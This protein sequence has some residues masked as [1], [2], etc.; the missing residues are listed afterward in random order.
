MTG[1]PLLET[2]FHLPTAHGRLVPR[3][4]LSAQITRATS[5]T[6]TLVSAPAGFGKTT[7][8]AELAA[9]PSGARVAWLSLDQ[10]D[11][12]PITFW[13]YVV[14]ALDRAVAGVGR[15]ARSN[16]AA[17]QGTA[18]VAATMLLNALAEAEAD[19]VLVLDDV[20]VIESPSIHQ[21]L[22]YFL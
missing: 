8:M 13:T 4:R 16:L 7:V 22:G 20:H 12:D 11:N 3:G 1:A 18:D 10:A 15:A 19:V 21:Q 6:L 17:A 14:E 2:K 5:A 9:R